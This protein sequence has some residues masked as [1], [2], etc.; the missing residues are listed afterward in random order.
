MPLLTCYHGTSLGKALAILAEGVDME[1]T[2]R[3]DP[4]DIGWGFYLS[5]IRGRA[6][7]HGEVTLACEIETDDFAYLPHPYFA[8]GLD[9]LAPA[10]AE[11]RL[12][13]GLAFDGREMLTVRGDQRA[14]VS[15]LIR[16]TFLARGYHG[17]RTDH[18]GEIVV[19]N[20]VAVRAIRV[21]NDRI[22]DEWFP[23]HLKRGAPNWMSDLHTWRE[24][25]P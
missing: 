15:R 8:Q 16:D 22:D 24:E 4:G 21:E 13:H 25:A 6:N 10:T 1:A 5:T 17:I 23:D 11:E 14:E 18:H 7:V 2:R 20:P 12:F 19:F 3:R 9:E